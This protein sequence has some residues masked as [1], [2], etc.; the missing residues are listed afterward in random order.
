MSVKVYSFD[1]FDTCLVRIWAKPTDLF[2]ELGCQLQANSSIAISPTEWQQLRID[3]ERAV[4]ETVAHGEISISDIYQRL[5]TMLGWSA[6]VAQAALQQEFALEC[7]SLYP[8]PTIVAKIGQLRAEGHRILY[9]SDMYLLEEQIR[10]LLVAKQIWHPEDTLYVSSH[11]KQNKATGALFKLCLQQESIEPSQLRHM[12]DNYRSDVL[13]PE[14]MGIAAEFVDRAH[15]N[16]YERQLVDPVPTTDRFRSLLAGTSRL[17]RLSAPDLD[18][19]RQVIWDASANVVAPVLF[20]YV[21]WCLERARQSQIERLYFVARDGQILHQIARIICKNWGYDIDCRYL[22]GSRQAWHFPAIVA[23]GATE[24][25]W[26]FDPTQFLSVR[27]VCERVNLIPEQIDDSLQQFEF[28]R[29][30]WDENL[31]NERRELLQQVFSTPPV[32][33]LIVTTAQTY[34]EM[35]LGYF[36]QEG[37]GDGKRFAIVDI[38]WHGR[39]QRSLSKLL[40]IGDLYPQAGL[41]GFYFGLSKRMQDCQTDRLEAYFSDPEQPSSRDAL[42]QFRALFELFMTADH[43]GTMKFDLSEG[44]YIPVLRYE[45][46]HKVID[47]GLLIQQQAI[48]EFTHQLS[49]QIAPPAAI[50]PDYLAAS[51]ILLNE[52]IHRPSVRE[53]EVYG[54]FLFA[55]DQAENVL[56]ELAPVYRLTDCFNLLLHG[57]QIHHNIWF[58]ATKNRSSTVARIL[59]DRNAIAV[60]FRFQ[61]ARRKVT[62][63]F[64]SS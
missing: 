27:S 18:L 40:K 39:L 34:R 30:T 14:K 44:K 10:H 62:S 46:N 64:A 50:D 11:W 33:E 35:A 31:S 49:Q 3:T 7:Q 8:V 60:A 4:R 16:R 63:Y 54:A 52:F 41:V 42:C 61:A 58:P 25:E 57:R 24:L 12:G 59:L 37:M 22:Y 38:G 6:A 28:D 53:S 20:G 55:E 19:D 21:S 5:A 47:W 23:V 29:S 15:L 48:C 13:I 43:G 17:T 32:M 45:K 51:E 56:Y 1:I 26:I 36:R 9:L 2:W